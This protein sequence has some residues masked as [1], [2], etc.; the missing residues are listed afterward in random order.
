MLDIEKIEQAVNIISAEKKIDKQ[1]I[2][3]IIEAAIKTAYKKDYGD[4]DEQVNATLNLKEW[5]LE[6]TVEKTVVKKV[7][8]PSIEI[9]FEELWEDAENFS[10]GDIIEI[11]VTD[12][13]MK[14]D[15]WE[16]F[17]RIASQA[18]RQVIIQKIWDSEKEKIFELFKWKEGQ[19]INMKV[20]I[21][22]W[23]KII[24][25]YNGNNVVLPKSEQVSR[26]NYTAWA[27]FYIYVAELIS[28]E[29]SSPRVVLSRKRP[30]IV[31][32]IFAEMVP[33]I[34][35]GIITIDR[36][37]RQ[38]GVKTKMLVSSNYDEIDPVWTLIGQRGI[39]VKWVMDELSGEKIDIVPNYGDIREIIKK[40]LSPAKV[41]KVEVD[42]E[43]E[44]SKVY[45]EAWERAKA[46]WKWGLNVNLASRLTWYKISIEELEGEVNKEEGE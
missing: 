38:P 18:A 21:V 36:V 22:E 6:L 30:E 27:R 16:S 9:S 14:D 33:E 3:E 45:I 1:K 4:K 37:V 20:E 41:V 19:V 35:E 7:E 28:S 24:F 5:K 40:S 12:E 34:G 39:R 43:N 29:T 26:D 31:P 42:E 15:D 10:E 11:D 23:G 8:N 46:V 2:I 17:G 25:D 13:I 44:S 32:A